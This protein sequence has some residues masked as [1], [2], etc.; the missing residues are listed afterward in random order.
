M[1][2]FSNIWRLFSG[3]ATAQKQ[4]EQNPLSSTYAV[5]APKTVTEDTAL[6]TSAVWACVKLQA[7]TVSSLPL[8]VYHKETNEKALDHYL[9]PILNLSPNS[10]MTSHEWR[11]TVML[12]YG[13]HG[14][15]FTDIQRNRNGKVVS[16]WPLAAQQ[17][18][19]SKTS[20]SVEYQYEADNE[21]R[22]IKHEDMHHLK[23]MGNGV[24]GLSM[25]ANA[26]NAIALALA[27]EEYG[28]LF[29]LNG[30]KVDSTLS[31]DQILTPDQRKA[32]KA[33]L[34]EQ[35]KPE[36]AHETFLMEG[37]MKREQSQL[38]PEK[39]QMNDTRRQQV[40]DIARFFGIPSI[41]I[42]DTK[43]TTTWGSGIE[44]IILGW[45]KTTLGALLNKW[46]QS[47]EKSLLTPAE[48][49]KYV[50]R[51]DTDEL[52]RGDSKGFSE[53]LRNNVQ[54]AV[55]TPNEARS[56][57]NLPQKEGGDELM[58]QLNMSPINELKEAKDG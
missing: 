20:R 18:K 25:I 23:Q 33:L 38:D 36:N 6:Q 35:S 44:Q 22:T 43:G 45:L 31:V 32:L 42:N 56:K 37:G 8:G 24:I 34:K 57:L 41:L 52:E 49:L 12:N 51:F 13:I 30:G 14:N 3:N 4:G 17:T 26:R 39:M 11:E 5:R 53:Y 50:I 10:V 27:S 40:E 16:L 46:E 15:G 1:I 21:N 54:G 28:A 58:I 19:V 55:M 47:L 2:R 48:R 29:Y 9:Y 7:A